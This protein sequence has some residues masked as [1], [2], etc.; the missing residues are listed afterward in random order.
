MS[1]AGLCGACAWGVQRPWP[2]LQC[3]CPSQDGGPT[4]SQACGCGRVPCQARCLEAPPIPA[5]IPGPLSI[6]HPPPPAPASCHLPPHSHSPRYSVLQGLSSFDHPRTELKWHHHGP[7]RGAP[8]IRVSGD[9]ISASAWSRPSPSPRRGA[10]LAGKY[11]PLSS[12][13]N[14]VLPA[15][16]ISAFLPAL[17]FPPPP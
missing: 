17:P 5:S 8:G 16:L 10:S 6:R 9:F 7:V 1:G 14:S 13:I 4:C 11:E 15:R 2:C 3:A 12:S